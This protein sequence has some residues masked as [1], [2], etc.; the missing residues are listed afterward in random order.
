MFRDICYYYDFHTLITL[1]VTLPTYLSFRADV[2]CKR[3]PFRKKVGILCLE[4]LYKILTYCLKLLF[5]SLSII[6]A[7]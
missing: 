5:W 4:F 2:L 1:D 7:Y 3:R 6:L